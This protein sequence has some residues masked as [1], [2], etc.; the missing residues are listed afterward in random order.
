[1]DL[2]QGHNDTLLKSISEAESRLQDSRRE[3][4]E[5]ESH[6]KELK[7]MKDH[8]NAL[9]KSLF[10]AESRLEELK[11][12]NME[13]EKHIKDLDSL[14]RAILQQPEKNTP[15]DDKQMEKATEDS[16][17]LK[18]SFAAL[19]RRVD[20]L[21]R[22]KSL[23]GSYIPPIKPNDCEGG[24]V[25]LQ[26]SETP[27]HLVKQVDDFV[28]I[29]FVRHDAPGY[30]ND[31]IIP[32]DRILQIDGKDAQHAD[33]QSLRDMLK[34]PL[35]STVTIK[36]SRVDT[37]ENYNVVALR[38]GFRAF[39]RDVSPDQGISSPV[40]RYISPRERVTSTESELLVSTPRGTVHSSGDALLL[41][42]SSSS[43]SAIGRLAGY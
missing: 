25:G 27:P 18:E 8:N 16:D 19:Q 4:M 14:P 31:R 42:A 21:E 29:N 38:H 11:R 32:G 35:H 26:V 13:K 6:I 1:M 24:F 7:W 10:E 30:L 17:F 41:N 37:G 22:E 36:L 15:T 12:E 43:L 3:V 20:E 9:V 34:G 2:I 28:D 39:G 5:K 23:R 33:L 40:Q